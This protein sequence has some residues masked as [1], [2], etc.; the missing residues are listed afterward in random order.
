VSHL[1]LA[2]FCRGPTS[3]LGFVSQRR[4]NWLRFIQ[5]L[6]LHLASFRSGGR[7]WLRFVKALQIAVASFRS[8]RREWL[9]FVMALQI[10]VASFRGARREWLRFVMALQIAV[11]S[12]RG[13]RREWLRFVM[14]LQIAVASSENTA[15]ER[16][17]SPPCEGGV[18]GGGRCG[19]CLPGRRDIPH[20]SRGNECEASG[21]AG[22]T[23]P[24]PP[25]ARGGKL[26][27]RRGILKW[28][29]YPIFMG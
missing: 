26:I 18:R 22:T 15:E 12:F 10:A 17:L 14:A 20:N 3:S 11:G 9:R 8:D 7:D 6:H 19:Y 5:A 24:N 23:P 16:E 2:S 25:F 27:D 13:G 29:G 21:C 4:A 28:T 1:H